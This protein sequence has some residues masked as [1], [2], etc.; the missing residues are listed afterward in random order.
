MKLTD[1]RGS[2]IS[3]IGPVFNNSSFPDAKSTNNSSKENKTYSRCKNR[4]CNK[5]TKN[6]TWLIAKSEEDLGQ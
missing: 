2:F 1:F 4:R 3:K 6:T 5:H